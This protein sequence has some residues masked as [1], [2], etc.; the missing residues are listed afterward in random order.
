M[1]CKLYMN[2]RY[3]YT[4]VTAKRHAA[5]TQAPSPA[6]PKVRT[7]STPTGTHTFWLL[8][9][10]TRVLSLSRNCLVLLHVLRRSTVPLP[11]R[12]HCTFSDWPPL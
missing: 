8:I 3:K 2:T 9:L 6:P 4:T 10:V 7:L 11:G 5:H 1:I 12:N